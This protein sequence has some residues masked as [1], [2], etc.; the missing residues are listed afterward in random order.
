MFG[1]D[2]CPQIKLSLEERAMYDYAARKF[3]Q[4]TVAERAN[5]NPKKIDPQYWAFVKRRKEVSVFNSVPGSTNPSIIVM[6]GTGLI[7]GRLED[8]MGGLYCETTDEL[9]T[10]KVLLGYDLKDGSVLNVH[11]RRTPEDPFRFAG[12][13][14][15]AGRCAWGLLHDRDALTYE[16]MGTTTDARGHELAYHTLQS[17]KRPEWP[18]EAT[19]GML[20][21]HTAS[22]YLYRRHKRTNK[23]EIFLWGSIL[24]FGSAPEKAIQLGVASTWL[25]VVNSPTGGRAKNFST[26]MDEA[27]SH[28]WLPSRYCNSRRVSFAPV[29]CLLSQRKANVRSLSCLPMK[30]DLPRLCAK[31]EVGVVSPLCRLSSDHVQGLLRAASYFPA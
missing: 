17:I 14:W 30:L 6:V 2:R 21:Q 4:D 27:D 11:E 31:A 22:C 16:R 24:K 26:L 5:F 23:T 28:Q 9:R 29:L 12:I 10:A 7:D 25:N 8:V 18:S 1:P 3:L 19:P 13:K 20:R 15:F